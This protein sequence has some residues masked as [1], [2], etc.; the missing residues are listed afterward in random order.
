MLSPPGS[1]QP[2][3]VCAAVAYALWHACPFRCGSSGG[4]L[5]LRSSSERLPCPFGRPPQSVALGALRRIYQ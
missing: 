1:G 2:L 4:I 5:S 3:V